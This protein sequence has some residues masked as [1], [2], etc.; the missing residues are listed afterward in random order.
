MFKVQDTFKIGVAVARMLR[1]GM[2]ALKMD[3]EKFPS[4]VGK[5]LT[6]LQGFKSQR[7]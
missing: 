3:T 4:N 6:T 1:V 2:Y 5:Y 7:Q